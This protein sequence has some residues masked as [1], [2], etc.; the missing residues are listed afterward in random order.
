M[1]VEPGLNVAH[2]G[3]LNEVI[4]IDVLG[5]SRENGSQRT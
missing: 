4:G 1:S 2:L 3:N 5:E